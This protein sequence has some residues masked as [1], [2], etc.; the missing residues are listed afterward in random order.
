MLGNP[1]GYAFESYFFS[2]TTVYICR[3]LPWT[4]HTISLFRGDLSN[5]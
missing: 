3:G 1:W 4:Y 2:E 5:E